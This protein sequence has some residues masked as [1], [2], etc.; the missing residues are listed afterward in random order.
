MSEDPSTVE[1]PAAGIAR[2]TFAAISLPPAVRAALARARDELRRTGVR[3]RWLGEGDFHLTLCFFGDAD[4]ARL[5]V[6][7]GLLES[8]AAASRAFRFDVVGI[9][10]FGPPRA[11]R[12][13]WA[14][15]PDPPPEL[16]ALADQLRARARAAGL[17]VEE[18]PYR[19]HITLGRARDRAGGLALTSAVR[20]L[21]STPFGNV[22]ADRALL[23]SAAEPPAAARY[24][25]LREAPLK[26][27]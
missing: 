24:R 15:V 4:A 10:F 13:V 11:P 7:R 9:G 1:P 14:G 21:I 16:A 12:V 23:M 6:L 17:P 20:S 2:R 18:R 25:K 26:G 5:D 8:A 19:P 22:I 27:M 3:V